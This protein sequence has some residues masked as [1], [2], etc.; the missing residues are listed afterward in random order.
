[1]GGRGAGKMFVFDEKLRHGDG[2][3]GEESACAD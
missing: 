1:M 3:C 2:G